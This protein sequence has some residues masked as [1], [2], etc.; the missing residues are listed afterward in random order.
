M[1]Q[2]WLGSVAPSRGGAAWAAATEVAHRMAM[3]DP[4][5]KVIRQGEFGAATVLLCSA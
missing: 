2:D 1:G 4:G 3:P 5:V